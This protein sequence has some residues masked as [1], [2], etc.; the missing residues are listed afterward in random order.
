MR[1]PCFWLMLYAVAF[2]AFGVYGGCKPETARLTPAAPGT[3]AKRVCISYAY[4][5]VNVRE[6]A[7]AR[8][9]KEHFEAAN[10]SISVRLL[11][12]PQRYYDKL[13][14]MMAGGEP[15]DVFAANYGRLADFVRAGAVRDLLPLIENKQSLA[16]QYAP[17]TWESLE[18]LALSLGKQ[19]LWGLPRDW[20]P[21]GLLLYNRDLLAAAG[22]A[23]PDGSWTWSQFRRAC[24]RVR[25]AD[26][27]NIT[28]A[29]INLYPYS[30]LTWLAQ[31]DA[32]VLGADGS[33]FPQPK[34]AAEAF[35]FI[36][37]LWRDGLAKRP[38]PRH[39]DSIEQFASG[40]VAFAFGTFYSLETCAKIGSFDWGLAPPLRHRR[41]ACSAL[42]TF[43]AVSAR[44]QHP[45]AAFRWARF[46]STTGAEVYAEQALAV[47]AVKSSRAEEL[48]LRMPP[49]NRARKAL[50]EA[51]AVSQPPP[52]H[53]TVAYERLA[54]EIR[55]G[56]ES[57]L[58]G[59][60][61]AAGAVMQIRQRLRNGNVAAA[62]R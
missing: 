46:L 33:I 39:D 51:V 62:S 53:P 23:E 21:A 5:A 14:T 15:P 11:E 45:E 19:G 6:V 48:F 61:D 10:P 40:R 17:A 38:D 32:P 31:A 54:D 44:S 1:R 56:L 18:A 30:V 22:V 25:A 50:R 36:L 55:S 60:T 47:P 26:L 34:Q 27:P 7:V 12:I 20:P 28:P 29:A 58:L 49:L 24:E 4:W 35:D 59:R 3:A 57:M 42:P 16:S 52:I 43:L 8:R 2:G 41:Q 37:G 13:Q 9:L